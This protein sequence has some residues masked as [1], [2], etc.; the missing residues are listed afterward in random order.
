MAD[1]ETY[2]SQLSKA[3]LIEVIFEVHWELDDLNNGEKFDS[4]FEYAVGIFHRKAT[5][6]GYTLDRKLL[7]P[8]SP[9]SV[10][11]QPI[12]QFWKSENTYP[13]I[14]FGHGVMTVNY[15][16]NYKWEKDFSSLIK[17]ALDILSNSY[18]SP[19]Q[20]IEI[21]LQYV[22]AIEFTSNSYQDI[23]KFIEANLN[24]SISR[25][26]PIEGNLDD[27]S[28][29]E[30]YKLSDESKLKLILSNGWNN[31]TGNRALIWQNIVSRTGYIKVDEIVRWTDFAHN[32]TSSLFV[33]ML[34]QDFY[35]SF[36]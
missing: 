17:E 8:N 33:T 21:S 10:I 23:R 13:L 24:T 27:I 15:G 19:H 32:I 3:P 34:K 28:L 18:E 2:Q 11:N 5:A 9:I 35:D 22:N 16:A 26:F 29:T 30:T 6:A 36:R 7:P 14:Q 4:G 12:V 1:K 25:S 31:Q 20:F